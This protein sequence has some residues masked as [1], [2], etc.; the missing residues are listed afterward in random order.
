MAFMKDDEGNYLA[1]ALRPIKKGEEVCLCGPMLH[2][3]N[4]H[5]MCALNASPVVSSYHCHLT[6]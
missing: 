6:F 5:A 3:C 2:T 1:Y 4:L